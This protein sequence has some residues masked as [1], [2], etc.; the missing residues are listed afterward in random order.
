MI[1]KKTL[2]KI[3]KWF[4][5]FYDHRIQNLTDIINH[6]NLECSPT[7]LRRALEKRGFHKHTPEIKEWIPPKTKDERLAFARK[8]KKKTKMYWRRGIYTDES[9][10]NTRI[11]RRLKIWRKRGER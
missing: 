11:L 9:T 6:F 8:H 2:D 7:T 4:E 1:N 10:F 3:K 5:G